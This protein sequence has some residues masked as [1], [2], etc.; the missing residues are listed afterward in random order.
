MEARREKT[1]R[2]AG[3]KRATVTARTMKRTRGT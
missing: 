3:R 1:K 2:R